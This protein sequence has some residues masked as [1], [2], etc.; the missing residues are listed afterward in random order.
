MKSMLFIHFKMMFVLIIQGKD[1]NL[2]TEGDCLSVV[3]A[4]VQT[5]ILIDLNLEKTEC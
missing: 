1:I 3:F 2:L 5:N 4:C